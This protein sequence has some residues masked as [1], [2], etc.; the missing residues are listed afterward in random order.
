MRSRAAR[1]GLAA[2][3]A[4]L[5]I[6]LLVAV[7]D[8]RELAFTLAVRES[9][10]GVVL[11]PRDSA[12]Q[13]GI[14]VEE[15][16]TG[17]RFL[18][19]TYFKPGPRLAVRVTDHRTGELLALGGLRDGYA[20]GKKS[21]ARL[22]RTVEAG[23]RADLCVRNAGPRRVAIFSGPPTD[24]EPSDA[25]VNGKPVD[26]DVVIEFIRRDEATVLS[27]VPDVFDRAALFHPSWV[28]AWTFWLVLALLLV[29]VPLLL[30]RALRVV[31][32]ADEAEPPD[33]R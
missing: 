32:A 26:K 16:F 22:D 13:R 33:V 28:G 14:D 19:A 25:T 15:S 20:D 3:A 23:R 29:A 1:A 10:P 5:G 18:L 17:A 2:M 12:C 9:E 30:V 21:T 7:V 24:N 6:L 8:R 4:G 31:D 27:L 11:Q